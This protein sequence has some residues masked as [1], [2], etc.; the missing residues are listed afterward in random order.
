MN[1]MESPIQYRHHEAK[2]EHSYTVSGV[3]QSDLTMHDKALY[4]LCEASSLAQ[5]TKGSDLAIPLWLAA[6]QTFA[7]LATVVQE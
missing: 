1:G 4:C 6:A 7:T 2:G 5:T 3:A